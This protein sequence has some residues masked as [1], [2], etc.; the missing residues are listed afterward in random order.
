M[1]EFEIFKTA[2]E[3][4]EDKIEIS[5]WENLNEALIEDY[6][7]QTDYWFKNGELSFTNH[8]ES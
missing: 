4:I 3:R 8:P 1:T 5:I 7:T 2:L 6:T